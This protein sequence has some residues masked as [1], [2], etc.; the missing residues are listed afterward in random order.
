MAAALCN[1]PNDL[2]TIAHCLVKN[3]VVEL[4]ME[5][6]RLESS[7]QEYLK[8]ILCLATNFGPTSRT[9]ACRDQLVA[10]GVLGAICEV[11]LKFIRCFQQAH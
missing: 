7:C 3:G 5:A 6:L 11:S 9:S 4:I 10:A 1:H 2:V 8:E